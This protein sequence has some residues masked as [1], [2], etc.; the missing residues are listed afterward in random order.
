MFNKLVF[1]NQEVFLLA[2][3]TDASQEN[4]RSVAE[5]QNK[6]KKEIMVERFC[7]FCTHTAPGLNPVPESAYEEK[8]AQEVQCRSTLPHTH[9]RT[10]THIMA[11][12]QP[13]GHLHP[14]DNTRVKRNSKTT[15]TWAKPT[16]TQEISYYSQ[17]VQINNSVSIHQW[18]LL[19]VHCISSQSSVDSNQFFDHGHVFSS[20]TVFDMVQWEMSVTNIETTNVQSLHD[21][22]E[23]TRPRIPEKRLQRLIR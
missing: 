2:L 6:S 22:T 14:K 4:R 8:L 18:L 20:P 19:S 21:A 9:A 17:C 13:P 12:N 10:L 5:T 7:T 3:K 15:G 11:Y 1:N 16:M 23:W